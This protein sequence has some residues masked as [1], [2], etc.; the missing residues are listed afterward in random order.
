MKRPRKIGQRVARKALRA[1]ALLCNVHAHTPDPRV[2]VCEFVMEPRD[3]VLLEQVGAAL[4]AVRVERFGDR[5][6]IFA[7]RP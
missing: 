6:V 7:Y 1:Q 2:K 4:G 5:L 3:R